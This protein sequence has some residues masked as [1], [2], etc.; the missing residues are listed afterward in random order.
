MNDVAPIKGVILA[1]GE[2]ADGLLDAV[3]RISG[4]TEGALVAVSNHGKSPEVL[5]GEIEGLLEQGP[6][7]VFTDLPSGSCA[8]TARICSRQKDEGAVIFGVN[9]PV[10]LDFV[11]HRDLPIHQLVP[12]LLKKGRENLTS[13]PE[14]PADA[15]YSPSG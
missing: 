14:F 6:T 7:I 10:L 13:A 5:N 15:D 3:S 4:M 2:M 11:F 12:R 1:H 9:L 8:I